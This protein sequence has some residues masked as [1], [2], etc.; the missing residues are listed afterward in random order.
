MSLNF[1]DS[2]SGIETPIQIVRKV[3]CDGCKGKGVEPDS[4][5]VICPTCNGSGRIQKQTGFMKFATP[6]H[7]CGGAGYMPGKQCGKCHGS[8]RV[9]QVTRI[10][11]R[12]P[13]G[14]DHN[15]KVRIPAKGNVGTHNGPPG[16]LII[17]INVTPHKFFKR[18]GADLEILLPVTYSEA[19]LGAK[20]EIP[21]L[22]GK[23]LLKIPPGTPS[24]RK[25]RIKG[26]GITDPKTK[27][28]GDMIIEIKI[29]PPS[30]KDIEVR[31]L[32]K[33][34][35]RKSPYNPREGMEP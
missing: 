2:A 31:N 26:K 6:C 9:D 23:T 13:A 22:D 4:T 16:D 24:G 28:K 1:L 29:V 33:K 8:G 11:V 20:I 19:A 15:S 25:L 27:R 17:T 5:R 32:L 30:T 18:S 14:V 12:I 35:E 3:A 10:R 34:I 21:T 7:R